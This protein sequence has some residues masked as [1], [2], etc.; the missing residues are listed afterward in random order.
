MALGDVAPT[1]PHGR[2]FVSYAHDDRAWAEWI[3]WQ[4]QDAGWQVDLQAWHSVPGTNF[5]AWLDACLARADHVLL[6]VSTAF[7]HSTWSAA[8]WQARYQPDRRVLVPVR[9][10]TCDLPGLLGLLV[11]IDLFEMDGADA[12]QA[13]LRGLRGARD[14]HLMPIS[15][16]EFPQTARTAEPRSD[17]VAAAGAGAATPPGFPGAGL[18]LF[19][20]WVAEACADR[21]PEASVRLI[22]C[23]GSRGTMM[24]MYVEVAAHRDGLHE[25]WPVG[26]WPGQ[27]DRHVV[28]DFH[29]TVHV[30]YE[31]RDRYVES[32]LVYGVA[33]ADP[34]LRRWARRQLGVTLLSLAELEGRWDPRSYLIRQ[35]RRLEENP[36]YPPR[37]YVPP[38]YVL[39]DDAPRTPP[40]DD[41]FSAVINWLDDEDAR[42]LLVLADFG[43]GKSFLLRELARV[44]P[45]ELPRV[46][47]MLVELR[48]LEKSHN[49]EDLIALHLSKVGEPNANVPA[50][51]RM[52]HRGRVVLLF[53]GFDELAQRVTFDRAAEHLRMILKAV[54]GR[55]KVVLTSRTQHFASDDQWRTALGQ[56]VHQL[57]ASRLVRLVDFDEEQIREYLVHL[58]ELADA[59]GG[60]ERDTGQASSRAD[61]ADA[62]RRQRARHLADDRLRLIHDIRDLLGLSANPRMLSYIAALP[63]SDLRAARSADGTISSADLYATLI[64]RWLLFEADRRRPTRGSQPSLGSAQLRTA[65][66]ALAVALWARGEE[67]LPVEE[68]TARVQSALT[69]LSAARVSPAEAAFAVG[70]G[71]LLVR[72]DD[73]RFAFAHRS[74]MEYLVAVAAARELTDD[75]DNGEG[76][77]AR[78]PL[79]DLMVDFLVGSASRPLLVHWARVALT[80]YERMVADGESLHVDED[81]PIP[82]RFRTVTQMARDNALAIGRRLDLRLGALH[83]AGQDLRGRDLSGERENLRHADLSGAILAGQRLHDIDLTGADLTGA[84]LRDCWLVRPVLTG[85]R[86]AASRWNRAVLIDPVLDEDA[87]AGDELATAIISGRDDPRPMIRP[88]ASPDGVLAL[89]PDDE[90]IAIAWGPAVLVLRAET[91]EEVCVLRQDWSV[92]AMAFT[93]D[94][95]LTTVSADGQARVWNVASGHLMVEWATAATRA[96]DV[97]FSSDGSWLAAAGSDHVLR[98]W[99][100]V[101]GQQTAAWAFPARHARA[102][103]LSSDGTW[104]ASCDHSGVF[105]SWDVGSAKLLSMW[106]TG[107]TGDE[108]MHLRLTAD[109]AMVIVGLAGSVEVWNWDRK[110]ASWHSAPATDA[111]NVS[112]VSP[113]G[114][115][116]VLEAPGGLEV[117]QPSRAAPL[118]VGSGAAFLSNQRSNSDRYSLGCAFSPSGARMAVLDTDRTLLTWD[119]PSEGL[120][121]LAAKRVGAAPLAVRLAREVGTAVAVDPDHGAHQ[122]RLLSLSSARLLRLLVDT[123][124]NAVLGSRR[125]AEIVAVSDDGRHAAVRID[126][127]HLARL[128][129]VRL[130]NPDRDREGTRGRVVRH[131][132]MPGG[133]TAAAFSPD[134]RQLAVGGRRGEVSILHVH[135]SEAH[136]D[137]SDPD[138]ARVARSSDISV[139]SAIRALAFSPDGRLLA[140]AKDFLVEVWRVA[141]GGSVLSR[142][143]T[144][145]PSV[146]AFSP[147]GSLVVAGRQGVV[148]WRHTS[149]GWTEQP[150]RID[151]AR[152]AG[153]AVTALAFSPDGSMLAAGGHRDGTGRVWTWSMTTGAMGEVSTAS[154]PVCDLMFAPDGEVLAVAVPDGGIRYWRTARLTRPAALVPFGGGGY[155]LLQAGGSFHLKGDPDAGLWWSAGLRR[156]GAD[157]LA[158]LTSAAQPVTAG[159]PIG[160]PAHFLRVDAPTGA[161]PRPAEAGEPSRWTRAWNRWRT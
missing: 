120:E 37:L 152:W 82:R 48:A 116:V 141:G 95:R 38:R 72:G 13:L 17:P 4:L 41:A 64:D 21:H 44:L 147:Q 77:L 47:P 112:A 123:D 100:V 12:R 54:T 40:R 145:S 103:A 80:S 113:D 155:A 9:V 111:A 65:V 117:W 60:R 45:V 132:E 105:H 118:R 71:S 52:L 56:E 149:D 134:G 98:V 154:G 30:L 106:E 110:K 161:E 3:A 139:G 86:L 102:L 39:L 104:L 158:G 53:D 83:L 84:D 51:L 79:S 68:L 49:V 101:N 10:E 16:P 114:T 115:C 31:A 126:H 157:D 63:E 159:D 25:V 130:P 1:G 107:F 33:L 2:I 73:D 153:T 137:T 36:D 93:A 70:S 46:V 18:D 144:I 20:D 75:P 96:A 28:E 29:R 127:R 58:F 62:T 146:V 7:L 11:R 35:T 50:V 67:A 19:L 109:G 8:E 99:M 66:D 15:E 138:G 129:L 61:T 42:L 91:L 151:L 5:V 76:L 69:D 131:A 59:T 27:P 125:E 34:G 122:Y 108:A 142:E 97:T 87:R 136:R 22:S 23:A 90:W 148:L 133:V 140:C 121:P 78:R 43:H 6:V 24:R 81:M 85:A 14:G 150:A 143:V 124:R 57:A 94:L 89:S 88:A 128:Q 156:F 32:E 26:V 74:F 160:M 119:F 135:A 92:T 55:A